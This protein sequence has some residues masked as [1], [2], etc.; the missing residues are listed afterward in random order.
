MPRVLLEDRVKDKQKRF[1]NVWGPF[2][3]FI[4]D[5]ISFD[6]DKENVTLFDELSFLWIIH[7]RLKRNWC[8]LFYLGGSLSVYL[9]FI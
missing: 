9:V 4:K 1:L 8:L 2:L 6:C 5:F 7:V 3:N